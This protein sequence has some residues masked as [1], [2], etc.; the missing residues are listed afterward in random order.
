MAINHTTLTA[1]KT[2]L[3]SIANWTNR[4]DLPTTNILLEAESQIYKKLRVREM[5]ARATMTFS[6]ATQTASLPTGFLDPISFRPYEYSTPLP[7]VDEDGLNEYR[8]SDGV[9][10]TGT[11]SRWTIVGETA[12]VD[13]LPTTAMSGTILYYK[14]PTALS[15]SNETNFMTT[16]YPS[17]LRHAC[18]FIAHQHMKDMDAATA[19]FQLME[20]EIAAANQTNEMW[21]RTQIVV[22]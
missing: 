21:R 2:T 12:Y 6:A 18:L 14:T 15:A 8:D 11:P 1:V 7:F 10:G 17:L 5:Q 9:L 3:G 16:R 22:A 4:T 20:A 19:S 13:V